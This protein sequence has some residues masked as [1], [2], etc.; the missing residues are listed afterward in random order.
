MECVRQQKYIWAELLAV[1]FLSIQL[2][3]LQNEKIS[4]HLP[5]DLV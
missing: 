5:Y 3:F 2:L 1:R 4:S